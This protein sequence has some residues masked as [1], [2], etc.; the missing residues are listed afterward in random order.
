MRQR[1]TLRK[2]IDRKDAK[3]AE[4]D[5]GRRGKRLRNVANILNRSSGQ[6]R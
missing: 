6:G 2:R 4:Q 5:T 1:E 3:L